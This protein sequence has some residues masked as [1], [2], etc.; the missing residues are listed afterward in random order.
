M[1]DF[2]D[3]ETSV[4][5]IGLIAEQVYEHDKFLTLRSEE[6]EI[7]GINHSYLYMYMLAEIQKLRKE[8]DSLK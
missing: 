3:K 1:S 5:V 7:N 6:H 8:I 4:P 2:E